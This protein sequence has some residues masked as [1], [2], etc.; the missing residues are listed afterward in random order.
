[1]PCPFIPR[2]L[3]LT[4]LLL[5]ASAIWIGSLIPLAAPPV[6]NGDK[7]QHFLGYGVLAA[8]ALA[9]FP[10]RM[11][12]AW[13]GATSMGVAVECAQYFVPYRSFDLRDM[14]ANA[15]GALLGVVLLRSIQALRG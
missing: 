9:A 15:L 13:L 11:W 10:P 14:L 2:R 12:R 6:D 4:L 8:L 5:W 3:A 1:M 7:I